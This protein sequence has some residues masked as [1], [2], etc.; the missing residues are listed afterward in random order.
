MRLPRAPPP[1]RPGASPRSR[2]P[3]RGRRPRWAAARAASRPASP[4]PRACGPRRSAG[5]VS[6]RNALRHD[7]GEPGRRLHRARERP[8]LVAGAEEEVAA[9]RADDGAS[10]VLGDGDAGVG[11]VPRQPPSRCGRALRPG[12]E[13]GQRDTKRRF[14]RCGLREAMRHRGIE[15][16]GTT[17]RQVSGGV[18]RAPRGPMAT[19]QLAE[20]KT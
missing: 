4:V 11:A 2:P 16:R 9:G 8:R 13:C 19:A 7:Q 6:R 17:H 1:R 10:R 20:G 18:G 3:S 15:H 14:V 12:A 5:A